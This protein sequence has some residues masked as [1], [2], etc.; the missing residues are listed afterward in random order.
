M[1]PVVVRRSNRVSSL[2]GRQQLRDREF[3]FR[4][5]LLDQAHAFDDYDNQNNDLLVAIR[6]RATAFR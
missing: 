5:E 1:L 3:V 2:D 6:S 4:G